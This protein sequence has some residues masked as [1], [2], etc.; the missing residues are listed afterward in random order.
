MRRW[1]PLRSLRGSMLTHGCRLLKKWASEV[2]LRSQWR[3]G[4]RLPALW[5]DLHVLPQWHCVP[6]LQQ[7][8]SMV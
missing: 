7:K 3:Q 6:V 1:F 4:R 5:V 2:N 8:W